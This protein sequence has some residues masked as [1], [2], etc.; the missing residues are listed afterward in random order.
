MKRAF[1][2]LL[3]TCIALVSC[4][5]ENAPVPTGTAAL[6]LSQY[7]QIPIPGS[8][9]VRVVKRNEQGKVLE[10]GMVKDGKRFGTW[11]I[12]HEDRDVPKVMASFVN[13]LYSGPYLEFN[14]QG[15]IDLRC[16]YVNNLLH[17]PFAR[18]KLGR[19]TEEGAYDMGQL[20]GVYKRYY[21]NRSIVQQEASYKK[22]KLHGKTRYYD[23]QGNV[24]LEYDYENGEKVGGGI[25]SKDGAH[26]SSEQ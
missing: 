15:Q 19:V 3:T 21:E 17:G 9:F 12:Y 11:L 5:Q 25:V 20:D 16:A 13:D 8:D 18:Y 22:G 23:E 26:A 4:K 14:K 10:E 1:F 24:L 6:D 7:E 2:L